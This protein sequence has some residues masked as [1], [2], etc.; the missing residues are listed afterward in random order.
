[1]KRISAL[2]LAAVLLLCCISVSAAEPARV[3]F[4]DQSSIHHP[5]AVQM[6]VDLGL[7][8][9]YGDD[10]FRPTRTITREETA[11]L[12][13]ILCTEDPSEM[14]T[15]AVFMDVGNGWSE[16]YVNY[17]MARKII[18]GDGKGHFRPKDPVTGRELAKMLL[19]TLGE[20]ETQYV[21]AGW[22]EHVDRDAYDRG[23]Y[24]GLETLPS[25]PI[26]RDGACLVIYNA[27]RSCPIVNKSAEGIWRYQ[28]DAL[29]NPLSY[30]EVRFGVTRYTAELMGNECADLETGAALEPG[31]T[32]LA[33]YTK[34][35]DVSTSPALLGREVD[36][37]MKDGKIV[38]VPCYTE[39]E[40]YYTFRKAE[41][42]R[43]VLRVGN[44]MLTEDTKYYRNFRS[45]GSDILETV[46]DGA[47]ITI[48][49]H[50]GD[51]RFDCVFVTDC[52][53]GVITAVSP[54][55]AATG[56]QRVRC[57]KFDSNQIFIEGQ[58]VACCEISGVTY[59]R[60]I[61]K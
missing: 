51:W 25:A 42:M 54:L 46:P 13:T 55:T 29:M 5:N 3:T 11:K 30:I 38:G 12:I 18:V 19:V 39:D 48:V 27:L 26:T 35:F 37:Y 60:P 6:L 40:I 47:R 56:G 44:G 20:D 36:I 23:L 9:G 43:S 49:D 45:A 21:G 14:H 31:Q 16:K 24:D 50:D 61:D 53:E 2:L 28:L 17:C 52:R 4:S 59:V 15:D 57:E 8:C 41:E 33:G 22:D 32:R 34:L 10:T 1:M 7:I 58:Q